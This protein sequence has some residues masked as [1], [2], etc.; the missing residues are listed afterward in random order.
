[1]QQLKNSGYDEKFRAEIL[2]SGISGYNKILA[3]DKAGERPIYRPKEWQ[4]ADRRLVKKKKKEELVRS[5]LEVL[6][7]CPSYPRVG[8]KE[9]NAS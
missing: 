5:I 6:H 2:K 7:F 8:V 4:A 3:A 1:M 9:V